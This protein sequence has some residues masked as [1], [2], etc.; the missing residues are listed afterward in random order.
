MNWTWLGRKRSWSNW[1]IIS[2]FSRRYSGNSVKNLS[3]NNWCIGRDSNRTPPER[4]S[5]SVPLDDQ[6][7]TF[8][9]DNINTNMRNVKKGLLRLSEST[10]LT[11]MKTNAPST[12]VQK[13]VPAEICTRFLWPLQ[14]MPFEVPVHFNTTFS[15][16]LNR[17]AHSV[18]N[19]WFHS[20]LLTEILYTFV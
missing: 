14:Q 3:Q 12:C 6:F 13:P 5:R 20:N 15:S 8:N 9:P 1:D 7:V 19:S 11:Y 4:E 16:S 10:K 2:T 17:V 18:E